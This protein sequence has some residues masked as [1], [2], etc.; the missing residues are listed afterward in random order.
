MQETKLA[1]VLR[2]IAAAGVTREEAAEA[3]GCSARHVNR[4][5]ERY[6]VTRPPGKTVVARQEARE[7]RQQRRELEER[8]GRQLAEG[9]ITDLLA[10]KRYKVSIRTLFRWKLRAL[11]AETAE[12]HR[13]S[14]KKRQK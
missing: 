2:K 11:T 12:K 5:M 1:S 8:V 10:A 4:L 6:G 3:L 9:K 7:R 13:K 14:R